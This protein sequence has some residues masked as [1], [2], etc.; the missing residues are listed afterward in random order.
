[1]KFPAYVAFLLLVT[2]S[3]SNFTE[4]ASGNVKIQPVQAPQTAKLPE[5]PVAKRLVEV[6]AAIETDDGAKVRAFVQQFSKA[7]LDQI[8]E[9]EHISVF[10]RIHDRHS[11]FDVVTIE[12]ST[13]YSIIA[14]AMMEYGVEIGRAHV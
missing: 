6:L 7:F 14:I 4:A 3:I 8:P 2:L 10:E 5:T 13:P 11:S 12:R 1:M 9:A